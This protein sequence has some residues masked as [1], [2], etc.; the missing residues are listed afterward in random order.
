MQVV[1]IISSS[2]VLPMRYDPFVLSFHTRGNTVLEVLLAAM[3]TYLFLIP[4]LFF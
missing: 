4:P 1:K 2:T 3:A